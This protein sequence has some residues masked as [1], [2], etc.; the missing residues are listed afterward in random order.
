MHALKLKRT[1]FPSEEKQKQK[2]KQNKNETK[3]DE[4]PI[5][6]SLSRSQV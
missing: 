3:N 2:Q 5:F 6:R 4:I 1:I